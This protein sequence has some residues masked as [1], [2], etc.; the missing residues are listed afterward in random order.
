[1]EEA[2]NTVGGA[3]KTSRKKKFALPRRTWQMNP[4]TRV[5]ESSKPHSRPRAKND[6]RKLDEQ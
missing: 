5:K 4:V 1:L 6:W 3:M 2:V